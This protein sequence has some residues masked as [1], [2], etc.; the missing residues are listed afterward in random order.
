MKKIIVKGS[1]GHG[2][3]LLMLLLANF[4]AKDKKISLVFDY[5][6]AVRGGYINGNMIL[7]DHP[8]ASPIITEG[9]IVIDMNDNKLQNEDQEKQID[10]AVVKKDFA[11][12]RANMFYFGVLLNLL[13]LE[14]NKEKVQKIMGNK[15]SEE[16]WRSME[17]G[18][19]S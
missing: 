4:L 8:I 13:S 3:K 9:D 19:A 15:F 16:N 18:F 7:S 6:S 2:V 14:L 11:S 1:G 12:L 5:D 10:L 17:M